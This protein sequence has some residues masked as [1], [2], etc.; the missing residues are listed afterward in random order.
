VLMLF[1]VSR[2]PLDSGT[3][4]S[5]MS[6]ASGDNGTSCSRWFF[7]RSPGMVQRAPPW[8]NGEPHSADLT[9]PNRKGDLF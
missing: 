5:K 7:V 3:I 2:V 9:S 6:R 8:L 1:E 4:S